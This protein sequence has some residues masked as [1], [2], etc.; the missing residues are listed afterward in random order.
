M[1][2]PDSQALLQSML[3]RL[4]IQPGRER[5]T[6][7]HPGESPRQEIEKDVLTNGYVLDG[8]AKRSQAPAL[9]DG[10]FSPKVIEGLKPVHSF[11]QYRGHFSFPKD[12]SHTTVV[13]PLE[14]S[15]PYS[16]GTDTLAKKDVTTGKQESEGGFKLN[17]QDWYWGSS[18]FS[19]SHSTFHVGNGFENMSKW[20]D[21]Q[22]VPQKSSTKR[23]Q[24]FSE[25]KAKR[26][27]QKLKERW[28]ERSHKKE[29]ESTE[30]WTKQISAQSRLVD[31][32]KQDGEER[33]NP[34]TPLEDDNIDAFM[35][36]SENFPFGFGTVSLL[37]EIISG[38]EWA[39]F[40]NTA[41][42]NHTIAEKTSNGPDMTPRATLNGPSAF[43]AHHS[44]S[45]NRGWSFRGGESLPLYNFPGNKDLPEAD[46]E[47]ADGFQPMEQGQSQSHEPM[48]D[49]AFWPPR[50]SN[51]E[52]ADILD[53]SPPS[54]RLNRKRQH[55]SAENWTQNRQESANNHVSGKAEENMVPIL[56]CP[57]SKFSPG[58]PP[59]RSV[60]RH[61][62]FPSIDSSQE[63]KRRRMEA[64][65]RV[66][67]AE[68]VQEIPPIRAELDTW[69][70][71]EDNGTVLGSGSDEEEEKERMAVEEDK[72]APARRPALPAW[73]RALK[74]KNTARKHT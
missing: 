42:T 18:R 44:E 47:E 64:N 21:M 46:T 51:V 74:R 57:S 14:S 32:L 61:P 55:H 71:E 4:K 7:K 38:Q 68:T 65:R 24:R 36:S 60:L 17:D 35:G 37:D 15:I 48:K 34:K 62:T 70:S 19:E 27:T 16:E 9:A 29:R 59:L 10:K 54:S 49:S 41:S 3:E 45:L 43:A 28:V 67:F 73:I 20:K 72:A 1:S 23:K 58:A 66:R 33:E 30:D 6:Y 56:G 12:D 8:P 69:D 63:S 40:L 2:Q 22:M 26:W 5:L 13:V 50:N 25:S 39:K 11:G 53:D 31:T 52:R